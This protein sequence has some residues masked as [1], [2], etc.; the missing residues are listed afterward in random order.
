M[1]RGAIRTLL[2]AV[3]VCVAVVGIVHLA[4]PD[5]DQRIHVTAYFPTTNGLYEGDEVRILGVKVGEIERITP[6]VDRAKVS[7]WFDGRHPVPADA[8]AA[9]LTPGLVG[10]RVIQL[11]PAYT[12]GPTM[13]DSAVIP[14]E[15]TAVPVE[16][17]DLRKQL[18]K[19]NES[20]QPTTSGGVA[21]AGKLINTAADN[22]RGQGAGI[23][24]ALVQLSQA[25][26]ALGDHSKDISGTVKNLSIL[27]SALESSSDVLEQLNSNLATV[28]GLVS[29]DPQAIEAMVRDLDIAVR[30]VNGFVTDNRDALGTT[31]DKLTS[32]TTMLGDSSYDIKQTL[33]TIPNSLANFH[34]TW[35]PATS[36][37]AG[38]FSIN[39]FANPLQFICSSIQAAQ[40]KNFEESAKLCVQYL[41]PIF[42]NRQYNFPPIGTTIGPM[43]LPVPVPVP[44]PLP[45]PVPP[46]ILPTLALTLLPIPL[47]VVGAIARPNEITYSEDWMRPDYIPP[48]GNTPPATGTA[49]PPLA[50]ET[51]ASPQPAPVADSAQPETASATT[52]GPTN[53]V[54]PTGGG[55]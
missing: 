34:N 4:R 48:A 54:I 43:Q 11:T 15:H 5:H 40:R 36:S 16:Y 18:A 9:I 47:P 49:S 33:H 25:M 23:R 24:S 31:T 1:R 38:I 22:L 17:D 42:K 19:L 12:G 35:R 50:A 45:L 39:N 26:S 53:A 20:M 8:Q 27:V 21:P 28:T 2:A 46:F 10:A 44:L 29:Q 6:E 51:T 7:F 41:A 3:L 14:Q 55:S 30:D 32:L 13:A 52:D 37:I